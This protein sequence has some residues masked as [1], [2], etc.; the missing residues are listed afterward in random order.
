MAANT[1]ATIREAYATAQ[2]AIIKGTVDKDLTHLLLKALQ[3]EYGKKF[4]EAGPF[5]LPDA[6]VHHKT[7]PPP[8]PAS[9]G[10]FGFGKK[11]IQEKQVWDAYKSARSEIIA[12]EKHDGS[13]QLLLQELRTNFREAYPQFAG[14]WN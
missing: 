10:I 8:P 13:R 4:A 12:N 7:S 9:S 14:L 5:N 6:F 2:H 3:T 1:I 11:K